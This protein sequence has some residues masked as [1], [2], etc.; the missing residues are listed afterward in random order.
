MSAGPASVGEP[1]PRL[2]D[3]G[4]GLLRIGAWVLWGLLLSSLPVYGLVAVMSRSDELA[5]PLEPVLMSTLIG[6]AVVVGAA[7]L[8]LGRL[9]PRW[10]IG[11]G[12]LH[13][14]R[15]GSVLALTV[16]GLVGWSLAQS[17]AIYG[18]VLFFMSQNLRAVAPFVVAS[19]LLMCLTSP[20]AWRGVR[21]LSS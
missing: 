10:L 2:P 14:E 1:G 18:L 7:G 8:G 13:P 3:D 5:A 16:L 17:V 9:L 19:G 20:R 15:L 21:A 4:S 6:V 11:R 12:T